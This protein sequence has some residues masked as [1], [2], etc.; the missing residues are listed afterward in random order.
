MGI[1]RSICFG[2]ALSLFALPCL[3]SGQALAGAFQDKPGSS[4]LSEFDGPALAWTSTILFSK[5][6]EEAPSITSLKDPDFESADETILDPLEPLN[7]ASFRFNDKLYFW[8]V[9]PAAEVYEKAL[10]QG[11]RVG[12]RNFFSNL[13]TPVRF[14]NCMLEAQFKGA[15]N[16]LTRL[17]L[18]STFGFF[19][20]FDPAKE[21]FDI[22]KCDADTGQTFGYWGANPGVYIEW[23]F[24]GASNVRDTFGLAGDF[25]LDVRTYVTRPIIWAVR[26]IEIVND[27]SLRLGEYESFKQ[28]ALDPYVAK[29]EAYHQYRLN[30]IRNMKKPSKIPSSEVYYEPPISPNGS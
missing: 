17:A 11:L 15:G 2:I 1:T 16:E 13:T 29:R 27:A 18:N 14:V 20:F 5:A 12:V 26:P 21:K 6:T 4:T 24:F 3:C 25:A 28:A 22:P 23:P 19:G 9:K 10:P 7:R 8:A 30:K